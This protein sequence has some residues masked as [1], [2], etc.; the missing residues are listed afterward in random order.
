[1]VLQGYSC[2]DWQLLVCFE[3]FISKRY[4][5][6]FGV[7]KQSLDGEEKEMHGKMSY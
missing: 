5:R 6:C 1:M 4:A 2:G 3:V 7:E